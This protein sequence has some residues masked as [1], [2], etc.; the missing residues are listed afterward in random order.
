MQSLTSKDP[1]IK[2]LP[3][4]KHFGAI[5]EQCSP[6]ACACREKHRHTLSSIQHDKFEYYLLVFCSNQIDL[7]LKMVNITILL[8]HQLDIHFQH[9]KTLYSG[10]ICLRSAIS[11]TSNAQKRSFFAQF[12]YAWYQ[13]SNFK[14]QLAFLLLH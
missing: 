9:M 5:N 4:G 10:M 7:F 2:V 13:R 3:Q 14:Q 1:E 12:F 11:R 8:G 6:A